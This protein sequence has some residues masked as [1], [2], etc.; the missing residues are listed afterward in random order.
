[1]TA[2]KK[3]YAEELGLLTLYT[4][5]DEE[6]EDKRVAMQYVMRGAPLPRTLLW[7]IGRY[8]EFTE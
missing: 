2:E 3:A 4:D 5:K 1:M 6:K 8:K 7:K